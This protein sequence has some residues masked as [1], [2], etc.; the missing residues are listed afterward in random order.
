MM[1]GGHGVGGQEGKAKEAALQ[2][3][4]DRPLLPRLAEIKPQILSSEQ[5]RSVPMLLGQR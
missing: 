1:A 3:G 5:L 4:E 2:T